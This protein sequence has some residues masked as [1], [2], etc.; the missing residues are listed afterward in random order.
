[1][2]TKSSS[3]KLTTT[4]YVSHQL[5]WFLLGLLLT[6]GSLE[7]LSR[8]SEQS[9]DTGAGVTAA[10]SIS[11]TAIVAFSLL[12]I[13]QRVCQ[14]LAVRAALF[15]AV[16]GLV[17]AQLLYSA[18]VIPL[19]A[20]IPLIGPGKPYHVMARQS[21]DLL[22]LAA[23]VIGFY[24]LVFELMDTRF[25][26]EQEQ[27]ELRETADAL[28]LSEAR[29]RDVIEHASE[30]IYRADLDGTISFA[31]PSVRQLTGFEPEELVGR[32][33][34]G[35]VEPGHLE[36]ISRAIAEQVAEDRDNSYVEFPT[37]D[38]NG[39]R[40]WLGA[41]V[42]LVRRDGKPAEIQVLARDITQRVEAEERLRR[43]EERYRV[44]LEATRVVPWEADFETL[45][46]SYVGPQAVNYFGYPLEDWYKVGFWERS[47]HPDDR[48][49][50]VNYCH[51][52]STKQ[53]EYEF[54]YRM[55]AA[56]GTVI[57][58]R[59]LVTVVRENGR[60]QLLRGVMVDVTEARKS[61]ERLQQSET[62]YRYLYN[63]TPVM[64]HSIDRQGR[65]VDV[66]QVWLDTLGY[67]RDE[68]IGR[69]SVDFLSPASREKALKDI[70]PAFYKQ[71]FVEDVEYTFVRKDG[72]V[73]DTLLTGIA[74]EDENGEFSHSL[75]FVIDVTDRKRIEAERE[76]IA[77]RMR[78]A[79]RVESLGVLAGGIAHD[80]N[81]ILMGVMGNAGLALL[82]L[83]KESPARTAVE[84]IER[85][86]QR[87]ADLCSQML[88]YA[89]G[90]SFVKQ[91][92]DVNT[93][94]ERAEE[95]LL[96]TI[97]PKA[98]LHVALEEDLPPIFGDSGQIQQLAL[99]LMLNGAEAMENQ[100]GGLYVS[101]RSIRGQEGLP[102]EVVLDVR[103]TGE[104]MTPDVMK[105]IF[106]PFFSTKFAGRGLGMAVV[107]GIVRGH[108]GVIDV[109]SEPGEGSTVTVRF[110]AHSDVGVPEHD[111]GF[112]GAED[113][114]HSGTVLVVDDDVHVVDV[115]GR[116]LRRC[117]LTVIE[118]RSG[119]E[120]VQQFEA[121]AD[122]LDLV[123]LDLTMNDLSGE[124]VLARVRE[125]RSDVPVIISSGHARAGLV[126]DT[127]GGEVTTF[128][129]KPYGPQH[130]VSCARRALDGHAT[131]KRQ[132]GP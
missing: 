33:G 60:P 53:N 75:A 112:A 56:D 36:G 83:P 66:N 14:G 99:N 20:D 54:E 62:K 104:G 114:S 130:L 12:Y 65:L 4:D 125:L 3:G 96:G 13:I 79:Q 81:N 85:S 127:R 106:D 9:D 119:Q 38:K 121:H 8:L 23:L 82:D 86:A 103:D 15:L 73:I 102:R 21:L 71:G 7:F 42:N 18:P 2:R 69:R 24:L 63:R 50:V 34:F 117:G 78:D 37:L 116:I 5:R 19:F 47:I 89:G 129:Q 1:V 44:M 31:S 46:F 41:S 43:N 67:G 45:R 98:N 126:I 123:V 97:E 132:G 30:A 101:T 39:D 11:A 80:F 105:R 118:A 57:W 40:V 27:A 64:M 84:E 91:P 107:H 6:A 76:A 111:T 59:D 77:E 70:L 55:L 74:M 29:Y 94:I 61:H 131:T 51:T 72:S 88:A 16:A 52:N 115:A 100:R 109:E 95:L 92:V 87:A 26:L 68:V 124:E 28:R 93:C 58:V 128:L 10:L 49:W 90:G 17:G 35:F 110:P 48:K 122:E 22:G 108:G 120:G 32:N 25:R 113:W